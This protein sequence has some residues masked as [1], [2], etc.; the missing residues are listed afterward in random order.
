MIERIYIDNF[1]C[2][3]GFE[4]RLDR[5]NLLLGPN[6]SGKSS[7]LDVLGG[8]A[9]GLSP[10]TDGVQ[11][12][13]PD[14]LTRWD[15]RT[16]QRFELDVRLDGACF[17]YSLVLE[18]DPHEDYST[19]VVEE[20]V[21]RDGCTLFAYR[22]G[23]VHLY[24][25]DGTAGPSFPFRNLHSFLPEL[26]LGPD[27]HDVMRFLTYMRNVRFLKLTPSCI[28]SMTQQ[29][30]TT[31]QRDGSNFAS[32]YRHLAQERIDEL[33]ELFEALRRAVPGFRSL[34]L[35]GAGKQGRRRDLVARF[36]SPEGG[37]HELEFEALSD[38]QRSLIVLYTLLVDLHRGP[39]LVLLDE[40][41][42]YVGLTE[43]QPWLHALDDA[44]GEHGQLLLISHHPEVIDE[45]AAE[46]P[47]LFER[48]EGGP[49][50]VRTDVFSREDGLKASEQIL[51]GLDP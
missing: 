34:A 30:A 46:R 16:K 35:V 12:F 5:V 7:L 23:H 8:L 49:V 36:D 29:E 22:D 33:H 13:D 45:L 4:L 10:G 19:T 1:K 32:W 42:N 38:G 40:P 51:R 11:R 39:R 21:E 43:I 18:Q 15:A 41:E 2:F 9:E 37:Q 25:N 3:S 28:G 17:G 14:D 47:L 6:G 26:E 48:A 31:L 27:N 24:R 20:T 44:L 50:R